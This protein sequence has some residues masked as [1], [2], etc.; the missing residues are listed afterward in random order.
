MSD[1]I[2]TE[3]TR[4]LW[5]T[6]SA[7]R[8]MTQHL[9]EKLPFT[10]RPIVLVC[11]GSDRSTGDSLGPLTGSLLTERRLSQLHVYGTLENPVHAKNLIETL[12]KIKTSHQNPFIIAIDACLGRVQ[13]V[14][15]VI[16]G[17]GPLLP[18]SALGRE[19]PPVG[20]FHM[21]GIVNVSGFME[22]SV[23][24]STRLHVVMKIA[25]LLA[26]TLKYVDWKL[27]QHKR[28]VERENS[29]ILAFKNT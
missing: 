15:T 29:N 21:T 24:Q 19:L 12:D 4:Y 13:N 5:D 1:H 27:L 9:C 14:G 6:P 23:L 25:K 20:D 26:G 17:D 22:L 28:A 10:E 18:G 3:Q 2:Y 16:I 7:M 11:I 8:E